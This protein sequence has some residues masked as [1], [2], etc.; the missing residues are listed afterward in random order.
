VS[1]DFYDI[2]GVSESSTPDEIKKQFRKLALKYHPDRNQGDQAAENKFKTITEA[3]ETLSDPKKKQ[4]YDAMRKY[5]A[6]AGAG[7][8]GRGQADFSQFFRQ[9]GGPGGFQTFRSGGLDGLEGFEDILSSLFGGGRGSGGFSF[10]TGG[11]QGRTRRQQQRQ[12]RVPNLEASVTIAFMEAVRGTQREL[13][14]QPIGTKL[15]VKI[16]AGIDS[17]GKIRLRGQGQ[18]DPYTGKNSDL[19][20]TV[21]VMPDKDFE[22]KGN[23]VYTKVK[24]SFKD[25]ILGTKVDVKTLT[26]SVSLTLKPGTQPGTLMRLKGLGLAVG[27]TTGDCYV[28]IEVEIPTTLTDEQ[29]KALEKWE[30]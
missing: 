15:K 14:L 19:I 23:D 30:G 26:K 29:R 4:E 25:A 10:S 16:P 18:P 7:T 2:L 17:G 5:G 27:K 13:S 1:K 24:V 9:G 8:G 21:K 28:R 3:Y 20:I 6:F 12:Q 22:R 11:R